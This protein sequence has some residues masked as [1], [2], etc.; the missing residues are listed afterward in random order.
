MSTQVL[1][2]VRELDHRVSDGIDV[3]MLWCEADDRVLV[4]VDDNRTG[5]HLCVEVREGDSPLE[6]FHH[7]YAYAAHRGVEA[8]GSKLAATTGS[9]AQPERLRGNLASRR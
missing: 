6:A 2:S 1:R 3:W 4:A 9:L 8:V 5:G 7:P